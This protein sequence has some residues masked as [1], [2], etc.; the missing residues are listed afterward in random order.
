MRTQQFNQI[1]FAISDRQI[2]RKFNCIFLTTNTL[3]SQTLKRKIQLL[4]TKRCQNFIGGPYN[5]NVPIFYFQLG[6]SQY[7]LKNAKYR[8]W[9]QKEVENSIPSNF[10][11]RDPGIVG[12]FI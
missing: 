10:L 1:S 6:L 5:V 11:I 7:H 2:V 4:V 8:F 12:S 3:S 9:L